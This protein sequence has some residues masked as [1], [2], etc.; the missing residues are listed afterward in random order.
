MVWKR[1]CDDVFEICINCFRGRSR[2]ERT[3]DTCEVAGLRERKDDSV[4]GMEADTIDSP[5]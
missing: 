5:L 2:G 4:D 1:E 3:E